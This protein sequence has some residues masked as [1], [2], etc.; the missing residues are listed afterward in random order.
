[1]YTFLTNILFVIIGIILA[2]LNTKISV[3]NFVGNIILFVSLI[4]MF[5]ISIF[6][7]YLSASYENLFMSRRQVLIE[8]F[9]LSKKYP[10][11]R[12][13]TILAISKFNKDLLYQTRCYKHGWSVVFNKLY[14]VSPIYIEILRTI[15]NDL[16]TK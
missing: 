16:E 2:S 4:S 9:E 10:S 3:I 13:K 1:M 14:E 12:I 15:E 11:L 7:I 6:S 5:L 8:Q